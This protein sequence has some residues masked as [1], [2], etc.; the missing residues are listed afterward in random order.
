MIGR[1]LALLTAVTM[2]GAAAPVANGWVPGAATSANLG[3]M[4]ANPDDLLAPRQAAL[5][6]GD[7]AL[8]AARRHRQGQVV[9]LPGGSSGS[10]PATSTAAGPTPATAAPAGPEG[11]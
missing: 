1:I 7:A 10:D 9:S 3:A 11:R 5:P 6:M 8:A 4:L 2:L